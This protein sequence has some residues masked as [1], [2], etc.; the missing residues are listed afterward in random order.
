MMSRFQPRGAW[1]VEG[2]LS[3]SPLSPL[4]Q[5]HNIIHPHLNHNAEVPLQIR[6]VYEIDPVELQRLLPRP[7]LQLANYSR[8]G[9]D[10][11]VRTKGSE[12][13]PSKAYD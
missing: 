6:S 7:F 3:P 11:H 13:S 5:H 9:V 4:E 12:W 2:T 8:L 10:V 1:T